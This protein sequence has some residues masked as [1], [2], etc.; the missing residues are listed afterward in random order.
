MATD[1]RDPRFTSANAP[2]V[3]QTAGGGWE[4]TE[5]GNVRAL[6]GQEVE[7]AKKYENDFW[8]DNPTGWQAGNPNSL[9]D[10]YQQTLGRGVDDAGRAAHAK[11]PQGW[12]GIVNTVTGSEEAR[13]RPAPTITNMGLGAGGAGANVQPSIYT[14]YTPRHAMEGF[15]FGRE[16]NTGKSAKDA[17]AYLSNQAPPPPINDKA[18]LGQWF[19]QYIAP[20]MNALGHK[21]T[22]PAQGDKFSYGNHEGDFTVD[23]G[24]GAGAEGGA[25][26]W[27]VDP[28]TAV[29]RN[30]AYVPQVRAPQAPVV[31]AGG[32]DGPPVSTT[33]PVG[34]AQ[35]PQSDLE[36]I[37]AEIDA[38]IQG[39]GSP[40]DEE[41]L[42]E[43]LR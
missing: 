36:R 13:N 40:L 26:A 3:R 34:G 37:Q 30:G 24:R 7:D 38:T 29:M 35:A 1:P 2:R 22:G 23:F 32:V 31:G 19:D 10:L 27:Q 20:G 8:K 11:N 25:L 5:H 15:N 9:D 14:G 16:Q 28:E 33:M 21:V 39:R 18:A 12:Q 41:A 6:Q 43:L 17:F 4:L 42:N